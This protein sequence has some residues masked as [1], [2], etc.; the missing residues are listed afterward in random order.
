VRVS[1]AF[2]RLLQIPGA[3]VTDVVIDGR[4]VEV[5]LRPRARL[6]RCPCGKP[7][8][9]VYDRRLRRWRH[10]DLGRCRLW[11]VYAIRRLDCPDCAAAATAVIH[12]L[13]EQA[14]LDGASD[15]PGYLPGFGILPAESV[16]ALAA[17]AAEAGGHSHAGGAGPGLSAVGEEP[18]VHPVA[19]FDVSVAG[20]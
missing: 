5:T 7:V 4:D 17:T 11:L 15:K 12:V 2:N 18:G 6:L 9:A 16:R 1:T 10:L 8:R 14:T 19:G 20:L 3:T 13:A